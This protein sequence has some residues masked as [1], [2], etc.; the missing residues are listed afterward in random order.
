MGRL[1]VTAHKQPKG[2][3]A[4]TP[5]E[6]FAKLWKQV[7]KEQLLVSQIPE[8]I[9]Q[10]Y[11]T[12]C[13]QIGALET[14]WCQLLADEI[15]LMIS[16]WQRKTLRDQDRYFLVEYVL[17]NYRELASNPFRDFD[18]DEL[19]EA[20]RNLH[21]DPKKAKEQT[22]QPHT[23]DMFA[24]SKDEAA[25]DD[26]D[27]AYE[28]EEDFSEDEL[29]EEEYA[30][31]QRQDANELFNATT[32]NKM[33]RQLSKV[34]HP[35]LEQDEALKHHKHELMAQLLNAR[36]KQDVGAIV[37]LHSEHIGGDGA[38]FAPEDFPRLTVLLKKQL[39][40]LQ[41]E[42]EEIA[43]RSGAAGM[44]YHRFHHK[45][46]ARQKTLLMQRQALM[47]SRCRHAQDSLDFNTNVKN[48]KHFL[49][50]WAEDNLVPM[51]KLYD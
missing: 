17:D 11:T 44:V 39:R 16:H 40:A 37:A 4:L 36:D 46:P 26:A 23:E 21:S 49:N 32:L 22:K 27:D 6:A 30:R 7:Q 38:Q 29:L 31:A 24:D 42:K 3:K 1:R 15:Y 25:Q 9:Q 33:F 18:L 43:Y 28:L 45:N 8:Q 14:R 10:F 51:F 35:D 34:L 2:K 20:L 12:Y 13:A 19:E 50:N 48:L 5:Q 47:D 41:M